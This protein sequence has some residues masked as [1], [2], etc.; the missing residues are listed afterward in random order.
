MS[1]PV[2]HR[3][4]PITQPGYRRGLPARNKGMKLPAEVLAP[5]EVHALLGSFGSSRTD[6][7]NKAI[8]TLMYRAGLKIGE[9]VG[10]E[11][12]HYEAGAERL[13]RPAGARQPEREV[14]IDADTREAL[15]RWLGVRR[16]LRVKPTA[17]LFCAISAD[18]KGNRLRTAYL[19]E[20]L[21]D[22]AQAVG[23]DR[24][25]AAQGL[26]QSGVEHREQARARAEV[27][28][29]G[30]LDDELFQ[31]RFPTAYDAWQTALDLFAADA[32]RH[33]T[34]IGHECRDALLAFVDAALAQSDVAASQRG[35]SIREKGRVLI[36][37]TTGRGNA[38]AAH[39]ASLLDY[40][41]SVSNLANRQEH[42]AAREVDELAAEDS[43]RLILHTIVVMHE[44]DR[45]VSA[46]PRSAR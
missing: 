33:S 25:V 19:R 9:I 35:G 39:V 23:I 31:R 5:A 4:S 17:P 32:R 41:E 11:R 37:P 8:V 13:V 30:Y 46:Q 14:V 7:R 42:R 26:R 44:L 40:W 15:D 34:R 10:L 38:V 45:L 3:G 24:R 12:R 16:A 22:K 21:K 27:L 43:R 36:G 18:A 2:I 1:E 6:L 28:T 29:G 20:V